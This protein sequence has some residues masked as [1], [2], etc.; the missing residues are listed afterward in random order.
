LNLGRPLRSRVLADP[1]QTVDGLGYS[2]STFAIS[3]ACL[4]WG[5]HVSS[6]LPSL[7][8]VRDAFG[9]D[10]ASSSSPEPKVP[11]QT[12][13][14]QPSPGSGSWDASSPPPPIDPT[15]LASRHTPILD[16]ILISSAFIAYLIV[17]L[18]YFLSNPSFRHPAVFPLLLA[19]PGAILR[20]LLA[21]LNPLDPFIDRFPLGT[22]LANMIATLVI[23]G[24]FAAQ[25]RP[26]TS[27]GPAVTCNALY[28]IQQGF[29]GCLSTV[30][31]FAVEARAVQGWR[32]KWGYIGGSVV[33]GHLFV[34][35]I[36]GGVGWADGYTVACMG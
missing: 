16:G 14:D 33:L 6:V 12:N 1:W 11:P 24:V 31:T 25:R 27:G 2:F 30:S 7:S 22:F 15:P 5:E 34:L 21:N 32:W 20:F 18:V 3:M 10:S 4:H 26:P 28:A 19:P 35:A 36:V 29:C 23:S 8:S 17:L 13:G 9:S